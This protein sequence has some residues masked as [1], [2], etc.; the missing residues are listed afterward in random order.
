MVRSLDL[1][2][3]CG[4]PLRW[5]Q[6][7]REDNAGTGAARCLASLS[8]RDHATRQRMECAPLHGRLSRRIGG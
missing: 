4:S 2:S 3:A 1:L 8:A 5:P 7:D 6:Q